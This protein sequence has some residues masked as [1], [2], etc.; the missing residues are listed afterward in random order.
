[1]EKYKTVGHRFIA[2]IIDSLLIF[3]FI[4]L[5]SF[6]TPLLDFSPVLMTISAN[7]AGMLSVFYKI[8]MHGY[9]GQTLGK[10][11]VKVKVLDS[12]ERPIVFGQAA[13]RSLPQ[14]IVL[15]FA[16]TFSP[17]SPFDESHPWGTVAVLFWG[18]YVIYEIF[19]VAVFFIDEKHRA[20]HDFIGGTVVIKTNL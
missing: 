11:A 8:L 9:Y 6:L 16:L 4:L 1:M 10:M 2:S 12:S 20:L 17:H 5:T 13:L 15:F 19:N 18:I 3:P 14:I 7:L